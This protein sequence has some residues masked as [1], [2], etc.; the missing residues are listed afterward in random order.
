[1]CANIRILTGKTG[2]R[3][4]WFLREPSLEGEVWSAAT[5][6]GE[7]L[8]TVPL[9]LLEG[10]WPGTFYSLLSGPR[11]RC[12]NTWEEGPACVAVVLPTWKGLCL[13]QA[14]SNPGRKGR[15][16]QEKHL[17]SGTGPGWWRHVWA[18]LLLLFC[19]FC[20]VRDKLASA[21]E[22]RGSRPQTEVLGWASWAVFCLGLFLAKALSVPAMVKPLL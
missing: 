9:G 6:A 19:Y 22:Q 11:G 21:E 20:Y 14:L 12:R 15:T 2:S 8:L 3:G 10:I 13:H 17:Y 1:M 7:G 5:V 4:T 16:A 18:G